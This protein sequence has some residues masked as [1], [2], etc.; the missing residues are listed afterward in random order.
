LPLR[1][2]CGAHAARQSLRALKAGAR[3][4]SGDGRAMPD[5]VS[6]LFRASRRAAMRPVAV[7]SLGT[8]HAAR[9]RDLLPRGPMR[10]RRRTT[11]LS[12]L[13]SR[14]QASVL[15]IGQLASGGPP[16]GIGVLI[17]VVETGAQVGDQ[18]AQRGVR[19]EAGG[20]HGNVVHHRGVVTPSQ[21]VRRQSCCAGCE[22][23]E[24]SNVTVLAPKTSEVVRRSCTNV[25]VAA[26]I[27]TGSVCGCGRRGDGCRAFSRSKRGG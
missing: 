15:P 7:V 21:D 13:S 26:P 16:S 4:A 1:S 14:C 10:V 8:S 24:P 11:C 6:R 17:C 19:G 3:A 25:T 12:L 5:A 27:R 2:V 18:G 22:C 9:S 20:D 23:T